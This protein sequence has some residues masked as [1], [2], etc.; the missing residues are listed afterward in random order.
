[1]DRCCICNGYIAGYG[2]N[3]EP[4]MRGVCCN[5]CNFMYVIPYRIGNTDMKEI[6]EDD[7]R[8]RSTERKR[9]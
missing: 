4:F 3:A 9:F 7:K 5:S 6:K 8:K 1:M 2:N